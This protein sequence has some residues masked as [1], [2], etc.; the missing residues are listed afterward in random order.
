MELLLA[1]GP[2]LANRTARAAAHSSLPLPRAMRRY[3]L[4]LM[5]LGTGTVECAA[6]LAVLLADGA[7][8]RRQ[9]ASHCCKWPELQ[10]PSALHPSAV[11][12][13]SSSRAC[14]PAA[15]IALLYLS[16][17]AQP[18]AVQQMAPVVLRPA[19][20]SPRCQTH[21]DA[22]DDARLLRGY[23]QVQDGAASALSKGRSSLRGL[24]CLYRNGRKFSLSLTL[25][26]HFHGFASHAFTGLGSSCVMQ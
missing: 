4:L 9:A 3:V 14:A 20:A 25:R 15:S 1:A 19:Q 6:A 22:G 23:R 18:G 5:A 10:P 16:A 21:A 26:R 8:G 11:A 12:A 2:T 7:P 17:A 13:L 24:P